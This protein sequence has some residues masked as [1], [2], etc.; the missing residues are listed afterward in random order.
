MSETYRKFHEEMTEKNIKVCKICYTVENNNAS[1]VHVKMCTGN[2][3]FKL[4]DSGEGGDRRLGPLESG[5]TR[6][7][8]IFCKTRFGNKDRDQNFEGV[9]DQDSQL[10]VARSGHTHFWPKIQNVTKTS[11]QMLYWSLTYNLT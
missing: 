2:D 8:L 4:R 3:F 1:T 7:S 6:S 9:P 10:M 5:W 11:F